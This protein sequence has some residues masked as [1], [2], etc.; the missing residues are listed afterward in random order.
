ME[1]DGKGATLDEL[2]RRMRDLEQAMHTHR[3]RSLDDVWF[4][5]AE[6]MID[7]V[8][9]H[10]EGLRTPAVQTEVHRPSQT[11]EKASGCNRQVYDALVILRRQLGREPSVLC[12]NVPV[13]PAGLCQSVVFAPPDPSSP[14]LPHIDDSVDVVIYREGVGERGEARRVA[15]HLVV[16]FHGNA[17]DDP[18]LEWLPCAR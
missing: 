8:R 14:S 13:D 10:A 3:S 7:D 9:S 18:L 5:A 11:T 16:A 17:A 4:A 1:R 6:R 15:T 2:E 12:W